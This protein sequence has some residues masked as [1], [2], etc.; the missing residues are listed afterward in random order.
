MELVYILYTLLILSAELSP[1]AERE[2][3]GWRSVNVAQSSRNR[4]GNG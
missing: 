4:L 2:L 3:S 1:I